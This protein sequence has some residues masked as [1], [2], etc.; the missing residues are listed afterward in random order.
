MVLNHASISACDQQSLS[1]WLHD[2]I[3][4]MKT[5]INAKLVPMQLRAVKEFHEIQCTPETTLDQLAYAMFKSSSYKDSAQFLMILSS[6]VSL[7]KDSD[8]AVNSKISGCELRPSHGMPTTREDGTPLLYCALTDGVAVG[9]PSD[10]VWEQDQI[11]VYFNELSSDGE[12]FYE[13]T[14][15]LDNLTRPEHAMSI[16]ERH[17]T[18]IRTDISNFKE[19]WECRESAFPNLV[20][21]PDVEVQLG[22]VN[23]GD[24]KRIVK[25]LSIIDAKSG[26][27]ASGQGG[28]PPWRGLVRDESASVYQ[29]ESWLAKRRFKS[30]NGNQELFMLHSS[31]SRGDRIHMRVDA[32][33]RLVEI[34]YIGVHLSTKNDP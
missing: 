7:L 33:K 12:E 28:G 2:V 29:N 10:P 15:R 18:H 32:N 30:Y 6:Q 8:P 24:L 25:K 23:A 1:S 26:D 3:N 22:D 11:D 27:W 16:I 31:F 34:G 17:Q 20:F 21:G 5:L 14:E 4:G 19:L 13:A 9:V